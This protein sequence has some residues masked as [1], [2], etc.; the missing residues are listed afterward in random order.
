MKKVYKVILL[1]LIFFFLT[2]YNP[3]KIKFIDKENNFFSIKN[4]EIVNNVL[5]D[6]NEIQDKIGY[7][8]GKNIFSLKKNEIYGPLE[9]VHFL[10]RIQVKKKYPNTIII[11]VFET[12]PLAIL[13]KKEEKY[14]ID[15]SAKLIPYDKYLLDKNLP[16]IFGEGA[17]KE[18]IGFLKKIKNSKFPNEKIKNFYY[19]KIGRWD[20]ELNNNQVIK[21]PP[22]KIDK[23]IQQAVELLKRKDFKNYNI[24]DLRLYDKVIVE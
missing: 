1:L 17:E 2:T 10:E 21:F 9:K 23:A 8:F 16:N 12:K 13:Y 15:S 6:D 24:I 11:K 4:I 22:D 5:I 7:I 3:N 19:F 18:F 14:L 20:L